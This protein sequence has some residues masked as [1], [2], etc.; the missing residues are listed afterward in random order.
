MS[1]FG[2]H[3][4]QTYYPDSPGPGLMYQYKEA[5]GRHDVIFCSRKGLIGRGTQP[6]I[7]VYSKAALGHVGVQLSKVQE[8][9]R[10]VS[11]M[12]IGIQDNG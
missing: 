8:K 11:D 1:S 4:F 5:A 12:Q 10:T 7:L 9:I 3:I 2:S 6:S